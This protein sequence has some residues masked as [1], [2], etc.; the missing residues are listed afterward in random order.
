MKS[1]REMSLFL[2]FITSHSFSWYYLNN[3]PIY[4]I[5]KIPMLDLFLHDYNEATVFFLSK[6]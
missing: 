6:R 1:T 5:L 2:L 4:H 3:F